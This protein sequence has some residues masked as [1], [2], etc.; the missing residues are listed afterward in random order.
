MINH[1]NILTS[2]NKFIDVYD[3]LFSF[4]EKDKFFTFVCNSYFK[5]TGGDGPSEILGNQIFSNYINNDINLMKFYETEGYKFLN[6]K[7]K[8]QNRK[9]N[10]IRVN[11]S[12]NFERTVAHTDGIGITLIYYANLSWDIFWGGHTLFYNEDLSEIE[13]ICTFKPGRILIFD[14]IIPHSISSISTACRQNRY[15][16]VI[17]YTEHHE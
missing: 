14:G 13:H 15:T 1:K 8:L 7:Y 6:E 11:C 2:N 4:Y 5:T 12:N 9:I 10:Q 17:Q 3:N 16:F